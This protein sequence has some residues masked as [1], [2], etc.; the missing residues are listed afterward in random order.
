M[1]E[2]TTFTFSP[3]VPLS[4]KQLR[5]ILRLA[6]KR[7][8]RTNV[9]ALIGGDSQFSLAWHVA[10]SIDLSAKERTELVESLKHFARKL[11]LCTT[12]FTSVQLTWGIHHSERYIGEHSFVRVNVKLV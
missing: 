7:M 4:F 1:D 10:L 2:A 11:R 3:R 9:T 8:G 5:G 6:L 12:N